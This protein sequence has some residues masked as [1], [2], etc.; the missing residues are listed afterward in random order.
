QRTRT[1][2]PASWLRM[3]TLPVQ[4]SERF[5]APRS[6]HIAPMNK[7]SGVLDQDSRPPFACPLTPED[8]RRPAQ[9]L[10]SQNTCY[11]SFRSRRSLLPRTIGTPAASHAVVTSSYKTAS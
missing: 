3:S 6:Q 11:L 5:L 8:P 7:G 10:L 1:L 4:R 9:T 2:S